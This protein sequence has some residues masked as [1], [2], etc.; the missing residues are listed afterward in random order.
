MDIGT[1]ESIIQ[2][3]MIAGYSHTAVTEASRISTFTDPDPAQA[4]DASTSAISSY[5]N[6]THASTV[7]KSSSSSRPRPRPIF[8]G[9]KP[10]IDTSPP[11][12]DTG[13]LV[14]TPTT[15]AAPV[16]TIVDHPPSLQPAI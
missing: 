7:S 1:G 8:K 5:T 14:Q 3:S 4:Q 10:I 13:L 6:P 15:D 16:P 2:T 12:S 9:P 11:T